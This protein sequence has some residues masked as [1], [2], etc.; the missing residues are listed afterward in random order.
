MDVESGV[1]DFSENTKVSSESQLDSGCATFANKLVSEIT[2]SE[3]AKKT[4]INVYPLRT[5][6][7][8]STGI[9][10]AC[11]GAGILVN[12]QIN[13]NVNQANSLF[14]DYLNANSDFDTAWN[15]YND[16]FNSL[17]K[18]IKE[19]NILYIASGVTGAFGL[20]SIFLIRKQVYKEDI[21]FEISPNQIKL[22]Y[23]F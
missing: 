13:N 20:V 21:S 16:K 10:L 4:K 11:L 1:A 18:L 23:R 9:G 14:N 8:I 19:R 2:E 7:Y 5:I 17:D 22:A 6:G 12:H 15:A 3:N